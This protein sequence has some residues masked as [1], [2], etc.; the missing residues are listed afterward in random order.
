MRSRSRLCRDCAKR[1][2]DDDDWRRVLRIGDVPSEDELVRAGDGTLPHYY[3]QKGLF[4]VPMSNCSDTHR[5]LFYAIQGMCRNC[6]N[7]IAEESSDNHY[8]ALALALDNVVGWDERDIGYYP[9]GGRS[10]GGD[11]EKH[12]KFFQDLVTD[13]VLTH[14]FGFYAKYGQE[15]WEPCNGIA[16][17]RLTFRILYH[18]KLVSWEITGLE[19]LMGNP[20]EWLRKL[21]RENFMKKMKEIGLD[22]CAFQIK[23][24]LLKDSLSYILRKY[25]FSDIGEIWVCDY[26][27]DLIAMEAM[28]LIEIIF[29][30][31]CV[32]ALRV[33]KECAPETFG[34]LLHYYPRELHRLHVSSI[35]PHRRAPWCE[36]LAD[37]DNL[38]FMDRNDIRKLCEFQMKHRGVFRSVFNGFPRT[39]DGARVAYLNDLDLNVAMAKLDE[40]KEQ[41]EDGLYLD[42]STILHRRFKDDAR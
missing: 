16:L 37:A 18:M 20:S 28:H 29:R 1:R 10:G 24:E 27:R 9:G 40:H 7:R 15:S 41:I 38:Q 12:E 30:C 19:N 21:S 35:P 22:L 13:E 11:W 2:D 8:I 25:P 4:E 33:F 26:D 3:T 34:N 17:L 5:D 39:D 36:L 6:V 23:K 14:D 31:Q 42:I 32:D